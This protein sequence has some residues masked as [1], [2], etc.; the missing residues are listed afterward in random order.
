MTFLMLYKCDTTLES[1]IE[2]NQLVGT[3]DIFALG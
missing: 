3:K 2:W 1:E